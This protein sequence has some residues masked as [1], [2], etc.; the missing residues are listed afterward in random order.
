[1]TI[2]SSK[3][4]TQ[5]YRPLSQAAQD[6][7]QT[8]DLP[9]VDPSVKST[10]TN[11][12]NRSREWKYEPPEI[13][14]E[15]KPLTAQDIEAIRQS[16]YEEG[17]A[18]GKEEGYEAGFTEGKETGFEAGMSEGKE[19]GLA[20]GMQSGQQQIDELARSWQNIIEQ[21]AK[22][23]AQVNLDLEQELV[24]LASK[25]AKAV[26]GVEV[27]TQNDVLLAAISEG[28]KVLPIQESQYQFQ[29]NP[30]DL[31]MVKGHFGEQTI[32]DNHWQLIEN[33]SMERGGCEITTVNNAVDMSIERRSKEVFNQFLSAQGVNHDPRNAG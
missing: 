11:A 10:E 32:Q 21:A 13:E 22:P 23:L 19:Q 9:T 26:I 12:L 33:P 8:W 28:I 14:E 3:A 7:A 15:V 30:I 17:L 24:I 20:Q 2:S 4:S 1:M 5:S 31:A 25:L 27:Q 6:D 16:A 29:M 18:S